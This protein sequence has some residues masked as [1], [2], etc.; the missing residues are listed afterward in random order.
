MA[1]EFREQGI[2]YAIENKVEV[3]YTGGSAHATRQYVIALP[4]PDKTYRNAGQFPQW[5]LVSPP[6]SGPGSSSWRRTSGSNEAVR[7]HEA[8]L[9]R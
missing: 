1:V 2:P 7:P 5:G 4:S 8:T 6:G 3:L 9:T